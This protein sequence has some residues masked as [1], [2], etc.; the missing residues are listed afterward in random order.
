MAASLR[1]S[2]RAADALEAVRQAREAFV[3]LN[4]GRMADRAALA[5]GEVL[6]DLGETRD[7]V[8]TLG[9]AARSL[10]ARK[11]YH[12]EAQALDALVELLVRLGDRADVPR[13]LSRVLEIH[14]Q[15]GSPRV[16]EL[17]ARL[18]ELDG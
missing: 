14:Q 1:K 17:A 4:D 13:Y 2:G 6:A 12:Y 9:E 10:R 18:A 8:A 5:E 15:T 7:A 11:A 3:R 16:A